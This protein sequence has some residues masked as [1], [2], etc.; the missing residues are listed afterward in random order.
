MSSV[1]V[2]LEIVNDD[3]VFGVKKIGWKLVVDGVCV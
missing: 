1:V 3:L 2:L